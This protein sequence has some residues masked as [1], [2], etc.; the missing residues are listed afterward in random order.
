MTQVIAWLQASS[1][2]LIAY[3]GAVPDEEFVIL[4]TRIDARGG[5]SPD[6]TRPHQSPFQWRLT[7]GSRPEEARA[8]LRALLRAAAALPARPV[9]RKVGANVR[10]AFRARACALV[11]PA[12]PPPRA[13]AGA[14]PAPPEDAWQEDGKAALRLLIWL[15]S[16]SEAE[17]AALYSGFWR[18]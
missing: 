2:R 3:P 14:R 11:S 1:P 15:G 7:I 17:C 16:L 4:Q 9:G 18:G 5:S 8:L 12:T 13:P 10:Q 6:T